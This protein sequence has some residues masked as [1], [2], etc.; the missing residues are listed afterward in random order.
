MSRCRQVVEM[1]VRSTG[2]RKD[3]ICSTS[4]DGREARKHLPDVVFPVG[5]LAV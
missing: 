5:G 1:I 4:S 2:E 3:R